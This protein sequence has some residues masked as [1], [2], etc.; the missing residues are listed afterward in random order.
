MEGREAPETASSS[1]SVKNKPGHLEHIRTHSGVSRFSRGHKQKS[2][3]TV[4]SIDE[5]RFNLEH[6]RAWARR[7]KNKARANTWIRLEKGFNAWYRKWIIEILLRQYVAFPNVLFNCYS[8]SS[9]ASILQVLHHHNVLRLHI[10]AT[11]L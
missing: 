8:I 11:D 2:S 5:P 7:Q 1:Q 3:V 4:A 10:A 9:P 6:Y